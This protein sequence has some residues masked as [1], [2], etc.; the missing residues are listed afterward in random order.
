MIWAIR[1]ICEILWYNFRR[2]TQFTGGEQNHLAFSWFNP[3]YDFC[4]F[5]YIV[6]SFREILRLSIVCSVFLV[7]DFSFSSLNNHYNF[8]FMVSTRYMLSL[9]FLFL[10]DWTIANNITL[11]SFDRLG[12]D[13]TLLEIIQMRV[14]I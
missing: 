6:F 3:A 12:I 13:E 4:F 1:I 5:L 11:F 2:A 8:S 14:Q 9:F 10:F 7:L